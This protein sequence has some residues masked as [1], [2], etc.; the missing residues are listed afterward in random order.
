MRSRLPDRLDA[1]I[2]IPLDASA[3]ILQMLIGERFRFVML[4]GSKFRCRSASL[5]SFSLRS[6]LWED[7]LPEEAV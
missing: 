2:G 1:S 4:R 3:P 7:D 5:V 6:E